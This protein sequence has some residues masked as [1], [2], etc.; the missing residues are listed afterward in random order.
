M[1]NQLSL[2]TIHD[3]DVTV[4][5]LGIHNLNSGPDFLES[6]ILID[7][8]SWAGSVEIHINTSDWNKHRHQHDKA[9]NNVVLHVVY[10]HDKDIYNE[11]GEL[12]PILELKELINHENY[13]SYERF[14]SSNNWVSCENQIN[15]ISDFKINAWLDR[16]MME[17][18]ERKYEVCAK[19]LEESNGNWDEV[20]YHHVFRYFG[21]KVNGDAMLT[22]AKRTP[23]KI[24]IKEGSSCFSLEA[25]LFGQAGMLNEAGT[26]EYYSK[27]RSEYLYQKQKY[28]LCSMEAAQWRFS[29][30]RPP[31]FPTIRIA[32]LGMLY[33]TST[34]LFQMVRAKE[35]V[36]L[37]KEVLQTSTSQYWETHYV[38]GKVTSKT[39]NSVGDMLLNNL[40]INVFVPI[41][42][43]YGKSISDYSYIDYGLEMLK[44]M[45]PEKN[46]IIKNWKS[47]NVSADDAFT[48]Q[49]LIELFE[50]YCSRKKC[51][52]CSLGVELLNK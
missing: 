8:V 41:C 3:E 7:G 44:S 48:S 4:S 52:T 37:V 10:S 1:Y 23:L 31:N 26:D 42:F 17:R 34:R 29:K 18:L 27:L 47:I 33:S 21:M 13:F 32:Q 14:L 9:Y 15:A 45:N 49:A 16:M 2:K 46:K 5:N 28:G 30:L 11:N 40:L 36:S 24:L 43:S 39:K 35:S 25:L 22:L 19:E 6:R 20:F 12:I 51:L 38:F 50:S